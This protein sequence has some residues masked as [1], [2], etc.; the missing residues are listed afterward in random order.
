MDIERARMIMQ[1]P[2]EVTVLY[3]EEPVWIDEVDISTKTV[4]VHPEAEEHHRLV[5][6]AGQ[7]KEVQE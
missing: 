7:L 3:Q 6:E 4:I 2:G 1:S 5:V